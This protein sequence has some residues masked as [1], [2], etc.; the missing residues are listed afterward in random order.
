MNLHTLA[1]KRKEKVGKLSKQ[2]LIRHLESMYIEATEST[3]PLLA[4]LYT[5]FLPPVPK[6]A[7]NAFEWVAK[8]C[9]KELQRPYL[10][11]VYCDGSKIVA[12]DGHR[13]H[14]ATAPDG[15]EKGFYDHTGKKI[16]GAD[17]T[18][19]DW[20]R[21]VPKTDSRSDTLNIKTMENILEISPISEVNITKG[22]NVFLNIG[23]LCGQVCVEKR[24]L[25][26][27]LNGQDEFTVHFKDWGLKEFKMLEDGKLVCYRDPIILFVEHGTAVVMPR[28][29]ER[30]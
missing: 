18:F 13:L 11:H 17:Y 29:E 1:Y 10:N 19:P 22:E 3:R 5:H 4:D 15:I 21:V 20:E 26:D 30:V 25:E 23:G 7:K 28:K 14:Y 6:R 24:L 2:Q 16:E 12:T 27:A 9:S 8:A